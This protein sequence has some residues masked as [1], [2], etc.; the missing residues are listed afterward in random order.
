MSDQGEQ[1]ASYVEAELKAELA[2]RD[3]VNSRS[4]A[5]LTGAAGIV[6]LVLA[7]FAVLVGKD[8]VLTGLA[9]ALLV[10]ALLALLVSAVCAVVA[11]FPWRI[12]LT[13]PSTLKMMVRDRWADTEVTARGVAAYANYQVIQSLRPGTSTKFQ[14]LLASGICQIVAVAMLAACTITVVFTPRQ[15]AQPTP[16]PTINVTVSAPPPPSGAPAPVGP[17][18]TLHTPEV[19]A[20][21]SVVP[22]K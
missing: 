11:G 9:K 22:P 20:P 17:G 6:T 10:L 18:L 13:S 7:V 2:R 15:E 3:S 5:A 4:A 16:A 21:T 1:Y 19:M 8:F 12:K 14:F